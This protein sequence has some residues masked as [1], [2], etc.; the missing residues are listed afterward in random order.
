M[1]DLREFMID[2]LDMEL[3]KP[4]FRGRK[5]NSAEA[6][7]ILEHMTVLINRFFNDIKR[8]TQNLQSDF[9]WLSDNLYKCDPLHTDIWWKMMNQSNDYDNL[10][11]ILHSRFHKVNDMIDNVVELL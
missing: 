2:L 8:W 9:K 7:A 4:R 1:C 10:L 5:E 6:E 11:T 3:H